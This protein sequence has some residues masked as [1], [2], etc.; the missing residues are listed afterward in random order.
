MDCFNEE[1]A[2]FPEDAR[3]WSK[4]NWLYAECYLWV[5]N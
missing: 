2:S 4:V 1:L 3:G 5:N